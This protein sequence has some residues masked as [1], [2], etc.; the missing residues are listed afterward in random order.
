YTN[1][2]NRYVNQGIPVKHVALATKQEIKAVTIVDHP[3]KAGEAV[4]V[5]ALQNNRLEVFRPTLA[6]KASVDPVAAV[7]RRSEYANKHVTTPN[8]RA[9]VGEAVAHGATG[10]REAASKAEAVK[11]V[12]ERAAKEP[13]LK[14]KATET[15]RREA[16]DAKSVN[17]PSRVPEVKA[18]V[19]HAPA[20]VL[21][22]RD[23]PHSD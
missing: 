22:N 7:A 6:A 4:H 20:R 13:Q 1:S 8:K 19:E 15:P 2:N 17:T 18:P 10:D 21:E 23:Q 11:R 9:A 16:I 5:G 14:P 3:A 12:T